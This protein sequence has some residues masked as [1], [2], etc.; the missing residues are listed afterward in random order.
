[1]GIGG[2]GQEKDAGGAEGF[3]GADEGSEVAGVLEGL[4]EDEEGCRA[5]GVGEGEAWRIDEGGD[6][7][8][9]ACLGDAGE[10]IVG[11]VKCFGVAGK[12][13]RGGEGSAE[14]D[15]AEREVAADGFED[16][17]LAFDGEGGGGAGAGRIGEGGAKLADA[18]VVA[19]GDEGCCGR[20]GRASVRRRWRRGR[21]RKNGGDASVC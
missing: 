1:M 9:G 14:E 3:G 10:D 8:R 16:E 15:G 13:Q 2:I 7:L 19:A 6:A 4:D 12:R 18:G 5:E 20:H 11:E 21:A 17:V